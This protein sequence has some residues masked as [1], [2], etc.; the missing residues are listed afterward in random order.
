MISP[1]A[2]TVTFT[3]S[4]APETALNLFLV[5]R[6]GLVKS[7]NSSQLFKI[8]EKYS[9]FSLIF[10]VAYDRKHFKY[11]QHRSDSLD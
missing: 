8:I 11:Q 3:Y 1:K 10:S 5:T 7:R 4:G 2:S 6:D 9:I